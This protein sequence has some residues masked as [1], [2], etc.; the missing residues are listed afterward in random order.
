MR[1]FEATQSEKI[2]H[3]NKEVIVCRWSK[4]K[5][6][7]GKSVRVQWGSVRKTANSVDRYG[8]D[9]F[10]KYNIT[11]WSSFK[12]EERWK[13]YMRNLTKSANL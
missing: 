10:K 7:D 8:I 13:I 11:G 12:N 5:R 4:V 3:Q 1:Y 2:V 9:L 6:N